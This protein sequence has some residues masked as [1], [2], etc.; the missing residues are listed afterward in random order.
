MS[1]AVKT[2]TQLRGVILLLLTALIWGTSFV[3]QSVGMESIEAFTFNGIRTLMGAAVLLPVILVRERRAKK[4]ETAEEKLVRQTLNQKTIRSGAILGVAL[5]IA[6]NF[7]Q[8]AFNYSTSGKIAFITALYMFFV[9]IFGLFLKKRIPV[10]TWI[11]VVLGFVGLGC[12][13]INPADITSVNFG[14][15]LT[16]IC[17]VFYAIHILLIERLAPGADGVK[18]SCMQFAVSGTLSV[19]CMFLFESP[20]LGA[21]AAAMMPLLYS[22]IMSCGLAYTFQIIGQKYTEA[23]VASLLMCLESVFGVLA[24]ALLLQEWL[25][26]LELTGCI[27]MFTAIIL[28]QLGDPITAWWRKQKMRKDPLTIVT[29]VV[30]IA[31]MGLAVVQLIG[32]W[33]QANIVYMPLMSIMMGCQAARFWK[34]S[35]ATAYISLAACIITAVCTLITWGTTLYGLFVWFTA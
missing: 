33:R 14:D 6:S 5:C 31:V 2:K 17:A 11:C 32:L 23:T 4:R 12:L 27:V 1:T 3:A 7:Q 34:S 22:G 30:S 35:K 13:C 15:V 18:L 21:I 26:P 16:L 9:P 29:L 28:S 10:L 19:I 8:F 25:T 24:G 20:D